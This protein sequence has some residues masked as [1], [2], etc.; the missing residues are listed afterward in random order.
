MPQMS[1]L[2]L[3]IL[4]MIID[5]LADDRAPLRA[6]ILAG[7]RALATCAQT[8]LYRD[9]SLSGVSREVADLHLFSRTLSAH[10]SLGA[11]VKTLRISG[12]L[13]SHPQYLFDEES[14]LTPELLPF[15]H[16]PELRILT[17]DHVWLL[18]VDGL[19]AVLA[20]LPK[21]ER[22]VCD[23]LF[24]Q[25]ALDLGT[26]Y[27]DMET[28]ISSVPPPGDVLPGLKGLQVRIEYGYWRHP[29]FA[30]RILFNHPSVIANLQHLD[31]SFACIEDTL[32]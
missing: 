25:A 19:L 30:N 15:S 3:D 6:C 22:L 4:Y 17:L 24:D 26:I 5:T 12:S 27:E 8:I 31:L 18:G 11:L 2:P 16:L 32:S 14:L 7:N 10:P 1:S 20:M 29:A 13:E 28:A 23:G 9:V 21:L